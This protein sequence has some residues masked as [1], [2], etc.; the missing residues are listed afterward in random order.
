MSKKV[1]VGLS[2]GVDSSVTAALLKEQGYEVT[3]VYMKNWSKSIGRFDCPWEED[4]QDAKKVASHLDIPFVM[5]DFEDQYFHRVVDY[6]LESFRAGITPNPDVMCNQEIKFKLFLDLCVENGADYIATGH[7]AGTK[8][9]RLLVA[10]DSNKDQTYFLYRVTQSALKKTIFPLAG[11]TKPEVRALAEKFDLP[12]AKR[13]E[14]MG[15]C[16]VGKIGIRDFLKEYVTDFYEGQ[17]INQDGAVVGTHEG[18]IF[19]TVGQ[20]SGLGVG[21]GLP[22][23]VT[24]KDMIKNEVYV[25]SDIADE[26]LWTDTLRLTSVHW[27]H[28]QAEVEYVRNRHRAPLVKVKS[29]KFL[30]NGD[31]ELVMVEKVRA[32]TPGQ[33]T[34][35]YSGN[36]CL[37]GGV[38]SLL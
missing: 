17:I 37:G 11:Y 13:K 35:F 27:I 15:I 24:G 7:Y 36:E 14:S 29:L 22:Y 10:K 31:V 2:G 26:A 30:E 4:Y 33:S 20:R 25:T 28:G 34:V 16:F 19:Y 6:M 12:T 21:G 9:G 3:G 5:Y 32:I 8:A 18:A 1:F 23:Y 38:V